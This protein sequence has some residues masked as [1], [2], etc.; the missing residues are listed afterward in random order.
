MRHQQR[1]KNKNG[2]HLQILENR[3]IT[4]LVKDRNIR[5]QTKTIRTI[6]KQSENE[7]SNK[8]N[9]L[10]IYI[11]ICTDCSMRYIGQTGGTFQ[12]RFKEH[13]QA[14]RTNKQNSKYA[15]KL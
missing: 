15:Q 7:G 6:R 10:G 1:T 3:V 4:K 14:G 13:I 5:V 12:T 9:K 2:P 8:F 11:L